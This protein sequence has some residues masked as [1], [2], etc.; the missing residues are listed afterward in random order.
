MWQ[1]ADPL[2]SAESQAAAQATTSQPAN[3]EK[4][5]EPHVA[6]RV[7]TWQPEGPLGAAALVAPPCKGRPV[8]QQGRNKG[9]AAESQAAARATTQAAN[10]EMPAEPQAAIRVATWQPAGPLGAAALVVPPRKGR[11]VHQQGRGDGQAQQR[12]RPTPPTK[13]LQPKLEAME[14]CRPL[15]AAEPHA[16]VRVA[17]WKP[18]GLLEELGAQIAAPV[19]TSVGEWRHLRLPLR[20]QSVRGAKSFAQSPHAPVRLRPHHHRATSK[21]KWG[22][23]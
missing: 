12:W 8:H 2:G 18:A 14:T 15:G 22:A 6:N 17:T 9:Q 1:P 21:G 4:A 3:P 13:L 10:P 11:P 7:A 20:V 16:V 5:A 23:Q 19:G